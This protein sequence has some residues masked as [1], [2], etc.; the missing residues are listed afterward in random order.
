[1]DYW[2]AIENDDVFYDLIGNTLF[3][4]KYEHIYVCVT[5]ENNFYIWAENQKEK[6]WEHTCRKSNSAFLGKYFEPV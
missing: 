2:E 4:R 3:W 1:M 6:V 5:K